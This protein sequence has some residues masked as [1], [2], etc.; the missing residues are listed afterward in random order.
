MDRS[1]A[2]VVANPWHTLRR[3]T[4]ARIAL[5]RAGVSVP[6]DAH[7]Q[8]QLAHAAARDAVHLPFDAAGM[9]EQLQAL[10]LPCLRLHSAAG[11]RTIYLR[12]PDQGRR[13][14]DASREQLSAWR[15]AQARPAAGSLALVLADGLSARAI[16]AQA[17]PLLRLLLEPLQHDGWALAPATVV[18]QGR[19]AIGDEIGALLGAAIVVVMIGER[20][21]LS[22]PDS[23]GLY[24]T[25]GP[26]IGRTDAE[27][28]CIS[29]VRPE[30][31]SHQ[32]AAAKLM[33]LLREARRRGLSGVALKDETE[34]DAPLLGSSQNFLL[35]GG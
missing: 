10:R 18:E 4:A 13:L 6:T 14:C 35:R 5:G 3:H 29:N 30:G 7:L 22:S 9:C 21:G 31:L 25:H 17:L 15:A 1:R 32:A 28:N 12:R 8:F 24:I 26:R 23:M 20:P 19:V 27:R 11:D 33:Y 16:H 2:P 34:A